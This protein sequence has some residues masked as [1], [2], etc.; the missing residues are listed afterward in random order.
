[1]FMD[2]VTIIR[3]A[4]GLVFVCVMLPAVVLPYWIIFRKAG[5]SGWLSL[6]VI[7]P[8]VNLIVLYVVAFSEWR[9]GPSKQTLIGS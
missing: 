8:M 6:L 1:M 3:I 4:A 5:F 9:V 7:I 2:T